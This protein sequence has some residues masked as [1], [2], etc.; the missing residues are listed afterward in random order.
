MH[1]IIADVSIVKKGLVLFEEVIR[2]AVLSS[3]PD[4]MSA[5]KNRDWI[6][7]TVR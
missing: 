4:S 1:L 5:N 6:M 3:G 7:D 2:R